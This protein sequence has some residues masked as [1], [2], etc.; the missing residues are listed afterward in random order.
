MLYIASAMHPESYHRLVND[1]AQAIINT[2]N[3]DGNRALF[4]RT[5][6]AITTNRML[7]AE[8][9]QREFVQDVRT[10]VLS[11]LTGVS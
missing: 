4:R 7:Q 2:I 5:T 11:K 1:T 3:Q 9:I 10:A 8:N 6:E